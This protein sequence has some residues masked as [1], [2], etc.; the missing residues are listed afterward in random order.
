MVYPFCFI[1]S[2]LILFLVRKLIMKKARI[3]I[4]EDEAI[5][6]MEIESQLQSLGPEVISVVNTGEKAI[7]KAKEGKPDLILMDIRIKG[8]T[9]GIGTAEII[10]HRFG[11]PVIFST[12]YLDEE[13]IERAKITMPFGYVLKPIQE[14]DLKVT[15]EM[16]LYVAKVDKERRKAELASIENEKQYQD[17]FESMLDGFA[18]HEMIFDNEGIPSD[19][20]F[21]KV[22]PAFEKLTG[23]EG[24]EIIGKTVL[25]VLP[26][27]ENEWIQKYGNVVLTGNPIRFENY[28]QELEKYYEV[29][30]YCPQ[31]GQFVCVFRDVSVRKL[32]EEASQKSEK[33]YRSLF[34]QS[35][36][37]IILHALDGKILDFNERA[38]E[39]LGYDQEQLANANVAQL[40]PEEELKVARKAL[41]ETKEKGNTRFESQ[42]RRFDG[43]IL[44]VE[45]SSRVIESGGNVIVQGI[46]RDIT[47]RKT[48]EM[49]F[50]ESEEKFR[51]VSEQSI[52]NIYIIQDDVFKYVNPKFAEVFGYTVSECLDNL[53]FKNLVYQEDLSIVEEQVEKRLLSKIKSVH[54]KF[55]GIRKNKEIITVEIFGSSISLNSRPAAIGTLLDITDH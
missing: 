13:R 31:E 55:R 25:E 19:Y 18:L 48:A 4:V 20:R 54:Y 2:I 43:T 29:N 24:K 7:K 17:L 26:N 30:V 12:A 22:N 41:L 27:I 49:A 14:R 32:A 16:A 47:E 10:R 23:L 3:L 11:I 35:N 52:I 45:V 46:V 39:I 33:K 37:A 15:V 50:L 21:L 44:N 38:L 6:A 51:S 42:F 9:D 40:H 5:I 28:T 8:E 1:Q 36:D 34:E 53:P